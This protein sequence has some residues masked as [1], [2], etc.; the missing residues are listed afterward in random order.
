MNAITNNGETTGS[1]YVGGIVGQLLLSSLDISNTT[2]SGIVESSSTSNGDASGGIIGRING[3]GNSM[4]TMSSITNEGTVTSG[5]EG[6]GIVGMIS[7][8][9]LTGF[10]IDVILTQMGTE[11]TNGSTALKTGHIIGELRNTSTINLT[12]INV[13]RPNNSLKL[14]GGFGS[15]SNIHTIIDGDGTADTSKTEFSNAS[16]TKTTTPL[17]IIQASDVSSYANFTLSAVTTFNITNTTVFSFKSVSG[18]FID[19]GQPLESGT[20]YSKEAWVFSTSSTGPRNIISTLESPL[21]VSIT[22]LKGGVGNDYGYVA[23][24]GFTENIWRHVVLT[25]DDTA[26]T[27]TLYINGVEV[28]KKKGVNGSFTQQTLRVGAHETTNN[29]ATSFWDG[30]IND[31]KIYDESLNALEVLANYQASKHLYE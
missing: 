28:S 22:E 8:T 25:F 12:S 23:S 2:H 20:N 6:G 7:N 5:S 3:D 30:F 14:V 9:T 24:A 1:R 4:V 26:K 17:L 15:D 11:T 31:V 29:N 18:S 21:Y 27:M 13:N 10:K 19:L 16:I